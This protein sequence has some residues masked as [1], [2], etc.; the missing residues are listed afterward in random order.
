M[1]GL[2]G[3]SVLAGA[4]APRQRGRADADPAAGLRARFIVDCQG[5][6]CGLEPLVLSADWR[7][8][9]SYA[10]EN[11]I[12]WAS[13]TDAQ[14]ARE[15]LSTLAR[16]LDPVRVRF[17]HFD[18]IVVPGSPATGDGRPSGLNRRRLEAAMDFYRAGYAP[19]LL[20]SGG[21]IHNRH[22]EAEVLAGAAI[23]MGAPK[24]SVI[25][26]RS[27]RHTTE[28]VYYAAIEARRRRWRRL[29]FVSDP[30][31]AWL[32]ERLTLGGGYGGPTRTRWFEGRR[33]IALEVVAWPSRG[34]R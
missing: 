3:L 10:A 19:W 30:G 9:T 2:A 23:T 32:I 4:S 24:G 14:G 11:K 1:I 25:R 20:A 22:V 27:A 31:Q 7:G 16:A 33:T 15:R 29:L 17:F 8:I 26:E 6:L 18:A 12:D 5:R 21:A 34:L 28:N 13:A